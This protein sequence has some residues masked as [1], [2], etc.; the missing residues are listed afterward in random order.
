MMPELCKA[1]GVKPFGFHAIRHLSATILAYEGMDIPSVQAVLRHKN[2]NTTARYIKSLGVQ[3]DKIEAAFAKKK[4]AKVVPFAP[5]KKRFAH[6][7][8]HAQIAKPGN[9][10]SPTGFEPVLAA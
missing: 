1:A 2:P 10:A 7:F 8:A 5:W 9:L 4:G 3:P 6:K